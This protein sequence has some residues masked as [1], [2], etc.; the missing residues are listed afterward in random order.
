MSSSVT[1]IDQISSTQ[2]AKEVVVNANFDATSPA[3]LWGRRA[4]TTAGLTWGYFGGTYYTSSGANAVANGTVTLTASATNYVYASATTGAVAVNTAG[5]PAGS[6][7]LYQ[8]VTGASAVNSYTDER[9]FQPSAVSGAS[10]ANQAANYVFAG[11]TSGG[12]AAPTWRQLVGADLPVFGASGSAHAPGAVP[13][14]GSTSGSTRFLREDGSWA[15][16]AGGGGGSGG[17][18]NPMTADGDLIVGGSDGAPLRLGAGTNGQVLTVVS[19]QPAWATPTGGGG[20][21]NDP[22]NFA[23]ANNYNGSGFTISTH[24]VTGAALTALASGRGFS[25]TVPNTVTNSDNTVQALQ[26]VPTSAAW[27]VTALLNFNNG[28]GGSGPAASYSSAQL[29]ITDTTGQLAAFGWD[30]ANNNPYQGMS[31]AVWSSISSFSSRTQLDVSHPQGVPLWLRVTYTGSGGNFVF[32]T[33]VDGETWVQRYSVAASVLGT[34][35][36]CG[37]RVDANNRGGMGS[38]NEG[39]ALTCFHYAQG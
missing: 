16:P 13:D 30:P 7:P 26:N 1:L 5:F 22:F 38:S 29:I 21:S 25:I 39:V 34:L 18:A 6:I 11:P 36:Q 14:P 3:M 32:Y 10:Y 33:S 20:S 37:L 17:M 2:A 31:Y 23:A 8:I 15:V 24:N 27:S 19:G 4:S 28:G 12:S 9:S 35:A